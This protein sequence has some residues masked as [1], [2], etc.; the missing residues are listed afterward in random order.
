MNS[1]ISDLALHLGQFALDN[2]LENGRK[3]TQPIIALEEP[4]TRSK[5]ALRL[6]QIRC[7]VTGIRPQSKKRS[8][9]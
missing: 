3:R 5:H 2:E 4:R 1:V 7:R 9:Q 8:A 6:W